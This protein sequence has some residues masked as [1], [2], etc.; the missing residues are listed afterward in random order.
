VN[1]DNKST[2]AVVIKKRNVTAKPVVIAVALAR[3]ISRSA[4]TITREND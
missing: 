4:P 3:V 2:A 1:P